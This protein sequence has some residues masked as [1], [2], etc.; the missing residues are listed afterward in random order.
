MQH[1]PEKPQ[2]V[3]ETRDKQSLF[4]RARATAVELARLILTL[5]T[6]IIGALSLA[7][8]HAP[9]N[10]FTSNEKILIRT[11]LI[12]L[13]LTV[14]CALSG[15]AADSASDSS[16]GWALYHNEHNDKGQW[17]KKRNQWRQV[18]KILF[19][20]V[21]LGF[22]AGITCAGLLILALVAAPIKIAA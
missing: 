7:A 10:G 17:H 14:A 2:Q 1:S 15:V 3:L 22:I 6:G 13:V 19:I 4:D 18:R 16:W 21:V 11:A 5:A 8:M 20:I 9:P 12:C